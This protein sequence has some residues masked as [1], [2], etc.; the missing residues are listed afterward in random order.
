LRVRTVRRTAI[1]ADALARA[2]LEHAAMNAHDE[3]LTSP[4]QQNSQRRPKGTQRSKDPRHD[5]L[6]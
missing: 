1:D 3:I 2:M 5:H 6:A 4:P